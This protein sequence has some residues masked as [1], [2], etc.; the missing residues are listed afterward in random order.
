M[1]E[2]LGGGLTSLIPTPHIAFANSK[3][4]GGQ[5]PPFLSHPNEEALLAGVYC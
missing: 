1:I 5:M 3:G 2:K 4:E